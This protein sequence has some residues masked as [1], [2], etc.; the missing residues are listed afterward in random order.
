MDRRFHLLTPPG[1]RKRFP[2]FPNRKG[3]GLSAWER[4]VTLPG[5]R[6]THR[7]CRNKLIPREV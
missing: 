3:Q 6:D 4:L 5:K 1:W 7:K 2:S